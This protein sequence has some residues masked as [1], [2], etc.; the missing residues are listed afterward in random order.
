MD[1]PEENFFS[2]GTERTEWEENMDYMGNQGLRNRRV[3]LEKTQ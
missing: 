2:P 3:S 1:D